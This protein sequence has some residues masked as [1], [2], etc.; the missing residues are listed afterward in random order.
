MLVYKAKQVIAVTL[1][2]PKDW[3]MNGRKGT[4]HSAVLCVLGGDG[5]AENITLKAKTSEEL[6][7]KVA[8]FELAKPADVPIKEIIP[9]F[10][11]GDRKPSGYEFAG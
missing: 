4:T 7:A 9:V 10:K 1:R 2:D 6:K 3:E 8:K 5:N 11:A